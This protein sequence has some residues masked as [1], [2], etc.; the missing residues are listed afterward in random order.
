[1]A[2]DQ[3]LKTTITADVRVDTRAAEADLRR[4]GASFAKAVNPGQINTN[5]LRAAIR[6]IEPLINNPQTRAAALAFGKEVEAGIKRA[7]AGVKGGP[8]AR[9]TDLGRAEISKFGRMIDAA[10]IAQ[11]GIEAIDSAAIASAQN[12]EEIAGAAAGA[13][14]ALLEYERA[15]KGREV[16]AGRTS[17]NLA[18]AQA[19]EAKALQDIAA[20]PSAGAARI[21]ENNAAASRGNANAA[22]ATAQVPLASQ[23]AELPI[24]AQ[25]TKDA[26]LLLQQQ[27]FAAWQKQITVR[28]EERAAAKAAQ[29]AARARKE[30][31]RQAKIA[32]RRLEIEQQISRI[33]STAVAARTDASAG[34]TA[35]QVSRG[36]I[37][38]LRATQ[39]RMADMSGN[40]FQVLA[41]V[42][43]SF[44][45]ITPIR[46]EIESLSS[47]IV[48]SA[49][50]AESAV[51]AHSDLARALRQL[52]AAGGKPTAE[53]AAALR[54]IA[55]DAS[56]ARSEIDALDARARKL[57][58]GIGGLGFKGRAAVDFLTQN[59][60]VGSL[61][62]VGFT[63]AQAINENI[64]NG[65][66]TFGRKL[67]DPLAVAK[68]KAAEL[69]DVIGGIS[70]DPERM[71][72]AIGIPL[73]QARAFQQSL[74]TGENLRLQTEF[75]L[76]GGAQITPGAIFAN[77]LKKFINVEE[78]RAAG[79]KLQTAANVMLQ[80]AALFAGAVALQRAGS[81]IGGARSGGAAAGTAI[82]SAGR[83]YDVKT[84]RFVP[85][86]AA[87][88]GATAAAN[89]A[90]ASSNRATAAATKA[91]T[92]ISSGPLAKASGAIAKIGGSNV[93]TAGVSAA[94]TIAQGG[95]A[96][97]AAGVFGGSLGGT[98]LGAAIGTAL[99]P[100]IGTV[101]GGLIGGIGGSILGGAVGS[102]I[103]QPQQGILPAGVTAAAVAAVGRVSITKIGVSAAV[104]GTLLQSPDVNR[105]IA[106]NITA[107]QSGNV[108]KTAEINAV[109][110]NAMAV[111]RLDI[112]RNIISVDFQSTRL[113]AEQV[114]IIGQYASAQDLILVKKNQEEMATRR[115]AMAERAALAAADEKARLQNITGIIGGAAFGGPINIA[116]AATG[117]QDP[118]RAAIARI[119]AERILIDRATRREQLRERN[120]QREERLQQLRDALS[121]A[122]VRQAG[123]TSFDVAAN[124][125]EAQAQQ[126][127]EEK[128]MARENQAN[129]RADRIYELGLQESYYNTVIAASDAVIASDEAAAKA[130]ETRIKESITAG[131]IFRDAAAETKRAWEAVTEAGRVMVGGIDGFVS[132]IAAVT[133]IQ[134]VSD[135]ER[136]D[137]QNAFRAGERNIDARA[138][139]G[140]VT[141]GSPYIV[142]EKGPELFVPGTSGRINPNTEL[143][144]GGTTTIVLQAAPVM[145]DGQRVG[146]VIERR[147]SVNNSRRAA[148]GIG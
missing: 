7:A 82:N 90:V 114:A 77:D 120:I 2:E 27:K 138:M 21:A 86:A 46:R 59:I 121:I 49:Q 41:A 108:D 19:K 117:I 105:F 115:I 16:L 83:I 137:A 3:N 91:A 112:A 99:L 38:N 139:G 100:G 134:F 126:A 104:I 22:I 15:N 55:R 119:A 10:A 34:I 129:S 102:N 4:I 11:G 45:G 35:S 143:G 111:Q 148:F 20:A 62:T 73:Q 57:T 147:V 60:L 136:Q 78:Q 50:R 110:Q 127:Q 107:L 76:R 52:K 51:R 118:N 29:E 43:G 74:R 125:A 109:V 84:G 89:A 123:M 79:E 24:Q 8:G 47:Q 101:I 63:A 18:A 80:A 58:T 69:K 116:G 128:R 23:I 17:A 81:F 96:G 124:I 54:S 88:G 44:T 132:I 70:E 67:L 87:A 56:A 103:D 6:G 71:A 36:S 145:I 130:A 98:A 144:R 133:G 13:T 146:E 42:S 25:A 48:E 141:G 113:T 94:I 12:V 39:M 85:G 14:K 97:E 5:S 32:E 30:A 106:E 65:A 61:F 93:F 28:A 40:P 95:G 1:M 75:K 37:S 92:A 140:P 53:Q 26:T 142:G 9:I 31:E 68:D 64:V 66:V 135:R 122:G 131:D 33:V 72:A